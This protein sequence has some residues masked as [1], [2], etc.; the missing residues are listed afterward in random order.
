MVRAPYNPP[1]PK[2]QKAWKR[3]VSGVLVMLT[4]GCSK[5]GRLSH[6][7]IEQVKI[8]FG[9]KSD[10]TIRDIWKR[11]KPQIMADEPLNIQRKTGSGRKLKY[12]PDELQNRIKNVPLQQ[13]RTLRS[14]SFHSGIDKQT[15]LRYLSRG[16]I[17]RSTS[18]VKPRLTPTNVQARKD[19][20]LG[21]VEADG[22]FNDM[23]MDVHVDEKWFFVMRVKDKFY[24][25]PDEVDNQDLLHRNCKHKSH[26]AKVMFGAAVARPRHNPETGEWWHGRVLLSPFVQYEAAQRS[27]RNRPAGTIITKCVNVNREVYRK[28]LCDDCVTAAIAQ[29]PDWAPRHIRFQQDNAKPHIPINDPHWLSVQAFYALPENGGWQLELRFQPPNSPDFNILDLGQFRAMQSIQQQHQT[30]NI[31]ELIAVVQNCWNNFPIHTSKKVWSSLQ[32]VMNA[33]IT[34]D[35]RNSYKLPHYAKEK[36]MRENGELPL[37]LECSALVQA[38]A[39]PP[40][41]PAN[42]HEQTADADA[43]TS[44]TSVMQMAEELTNNLANLSLQAVA[45]EDLWENLGDDLEWDDSAGHGE[46]DAVV[47]DMDI[48]GLEEAQA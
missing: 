13:R 33:C 18:N 21:H 45:E 43:G 48:D 44:P 25:L 42:N 35:G 36:F 3:R 22:C 31:D 29:W 28:W 8:K 32:L 41:P 12:L 16:L 15:L 23:L 20:C 9:Y 7:L 40:T 19:Y 2:E 47:E 14:L 24:L 1:G 6:E 37:R 38:A 10:R 5:K 11:Y 30:R 27:S 46:E 39:A 17:A 34:V 26:I 4:K